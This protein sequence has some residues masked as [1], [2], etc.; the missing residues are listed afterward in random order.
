MRFDSSRVSSAALAVAMVALSACSDK[1]GPTATSPELRPQHAICLTC[2]G[3]G[4]DEAPPS[5]SSVNF[6][7]RTFSINGPSVGYTASVSDPGGASGLSLV[8][9]LI[10]GSV[11]RRFAAIELS[12]GVGIT[13]CT[14]SSTISAAGFAPGS[15]TF[16]L[17]LLDEFGAVQSTVNIAVTLVSGTV[18]Q[19]DTGTV[20]A[21]SQVILPSTTLTI[22]APPISLR[23]TVIS[24]IASFYRCQDSSLHPAAAAGLPGVRSRNPLR[25][26]SGDMHVRHAARLALGCHQRAGA[27]RAAGD[28]CRRLVPWFSGST[29]TSRSRARNPSVRSAR[30]PL[31]S[32]SVVGPPR[33]TSRPYRIRTSIC[34]A[35]QYRVG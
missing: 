18:I 15:A 21:I 20:V 33:D 30:A 5:I 6:P 4:G 31:R 9:T 16:R 28:R 2:G 8:G 25:G 24:K 17:K 3:G 11:T 13:S 23:T 14:G 7:N 32:Q 34:P 1:V 27:A 22:G 35:R 19:G 26:R 10:Q 29:S 12:C